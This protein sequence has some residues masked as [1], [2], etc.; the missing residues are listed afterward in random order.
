[1]DWGIFGTI[2]RK[3]NRRSIDLA[4][5]YI[6]ACIYLVLGSWRFFR[7]TYMVN[8]PSIAPNDFVVSDRGGVVENRHGVHAAVVDS[9]G[10]ILY[11]VGDPTRVTLARSAAKPAQALAILETGARDLFGFDEGDVALMCASHSSEDR[12]VTKARDI[13]AKANVKE[14]NLRCG[15]HK[16]LSDTVYRSWIKKDYEPTA[17]DSNCSGKHAGMLAGSKALNADVHDYH[18]SSAP[19]Q[20]KVKEVMAETTGLPQDEI[21]WGVDGC[22]LPAPAFPLHGL[23]RMYAGFAAAGPT[24]NKGRIFHAMAH[25]PELVAGEGRFCTEL[26]NAYEGSL[27]GKLGADGCYGVGVLPCEETERIGAQ[28]AVGIAVKIEDG[29]I[30]ILYAAVM[31]LL[32]RLHLG[33]PEARRKLNSFHLPKIVNTAG[34]VTGQ[35]THPFELRPIDA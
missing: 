34:Q 28:G 19:M 16:P 27:I 26:M 30:N 1:M 13:L 17:V 8:M 22:N 25:R 20:L 15:G 10:K 31:E 5:A 12:H 21:A 29:N 33:Q 14:D 4:A 18:L 6:S 9:G 2:A 23:A 35:I 11:A 7:H 24:S 32:E 3:K